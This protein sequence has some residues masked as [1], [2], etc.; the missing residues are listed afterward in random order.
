MRAKGEEEFEHQHKGNSKIH[1]HI[2]S[3]YGNEGS[4]G[5]LCM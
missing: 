2:P 3:A 1:H 4:G 5:R